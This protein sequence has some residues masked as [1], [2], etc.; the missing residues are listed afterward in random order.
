MDYQ[1]E[2]AE[3]GDY[4]RNLERTTKD[5]KARDRV[6][7]IRFLKIGKAMTQEQAGALIGLKVRQSQRLWKQYREEGVSKLCQNNYVGGQS[8]LSRAEQD[9]LRERL[10]DDDI[11]TLEQ[12]RVWLKQEFRVDYTLGGVSCLFQRMKV[13]LKTGRPSNVKQD[14]EQ[15]E[16]FAKKNIRS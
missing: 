11:G 2:I 10:C 5:L 13:K 1:V 14:S 16:E 8:K 4:L 15:M 6:R 3:S 12:A 9:Q 7:F